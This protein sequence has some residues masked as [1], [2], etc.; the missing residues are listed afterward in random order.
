MFP[1][2]MVV[3]GHV[4][5]SWCRVNLYFQF[6]QIWEFSKATKILPLADLLSKSMS[7]LKLLTGVLTNTPGRGVWES[8]KRE[9]IG[10]AKTL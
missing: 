4:Y 2:N 6:S 9:A 3:S 7:F 8:R 1:V 10:G 5:H